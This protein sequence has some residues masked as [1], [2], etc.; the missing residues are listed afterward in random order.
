MTGTNTP[1]LLSQIIFAST[2]SPALKSP[3][4]LSNKVFTSICWSLLLAF[5]EREQT[6]DGKS[7]LIAKQKRVELGDI[8]GNNFQ[9]ISGLEP[10]ERI[11][12]SGLINLR[13][14]MPINPK[15][16]NSK[17]NS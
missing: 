10:G 1:G 3:W 16:V 11:I 8:K 17:D 9:V 15:E 13:E 12:V 7:Q 14:G 4:E 6:K 5:G 2:D